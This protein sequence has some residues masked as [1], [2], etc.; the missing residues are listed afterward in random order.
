MSGLV[1]PL[2]ELLGFALLLMVLESVAGYRR[3]RRLYQPG[4]TLCSFALGLGSVGLAALNTAVVTAL[5]A[6]A[7]SH[8]V[9]DLGHTGVAYGL[10]FV[11]VD[12]VYYWGHR[13]SHHWRWFWAAHRVHHS[14]RRFNLATALR[15]S[16]TPS[17]LGP[18]V[19]VLP[20]MVLGLRPDIIVLSYGLSQGYQ[21]LLHTELV[22]HLGPIEGFLNT[23]RHH[24]IHHASN[25]IYLD[26]NFG[27]VLIVWDRLFGTFAEAR[28]GVPPVYGIAGEAPSDNP[29]RIA[30]AEYYAMG[31]DF[32]GRVR[33]LRSRARA[34][35]RVVSPTRPATRTKLQSGECAVVA[36]QAHLT[37][38][39][40]S[41]REPS[42]TLRPL[43]LRDELPRG[44][45]SVVRHRTQVLSTQ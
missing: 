5:V 4:D 12:F 39:L 18:S 25:P 38:S 24:R 20:A 16:W 19:F 22:G 10:S 32:V 1:T 8:R 41:Q 29:F 23:P 35:R 3:G 43:S 6:A 11:L 45:S 17:F 15:Q 40:S 13:A 37:Q 26:R 34:R 14:S 33:S 7:W 31:R 9:A 21:F 27:G 44:Q 30:T 36:A 2:P 42:L 28:P